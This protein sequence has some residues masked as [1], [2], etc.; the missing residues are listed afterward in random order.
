[1]ETRIQRIARMFCEGSTEKA[2]LFVALLDAGVSWAKSC[3]RNNRPGDARPMNATTHPQ[4]VP[5]REEWI[6]T[7]WG[8]VVLIQSTS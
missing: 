3:L 2:L 8:W 4:E 1:M 5:H 6:E 7:P